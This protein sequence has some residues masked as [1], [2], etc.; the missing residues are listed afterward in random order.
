MKWLEKFEN[1]LLAVFVGM[2]I[3]VLII[4][5]YVSIKLI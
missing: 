3:I 4:Y 1:F 5:I 2:G